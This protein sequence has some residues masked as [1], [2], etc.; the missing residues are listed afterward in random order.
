MTHEPEHL[1]PVEAAAFLGSSVQWV[2][3]LAKRGK[4]GRQIAKGYYIFTK[5]EL[6][7]YKDQPRDKGGRPPK[8]PAT[9]SRKTQ[10]LANEEQ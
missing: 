7:A 10:G 4:L 6:Q 9:R 8:N 1:N 3:S 2:H 5:E